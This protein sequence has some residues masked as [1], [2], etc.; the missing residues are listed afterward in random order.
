MAFVNLNNSCPQRQFLLAWRDGKICC[1]LCG[2]QNTY[3]FSRNGLRN[4]YR[5]SHK[6]AEF[7][8]SAFKD[9][10]KVLR[11]FVTNE[12]RENLITLS[13]Q[14]RKSVGSTLFHLK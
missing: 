11:E 2:F 7:S 4:H 12:T 10:A 5:A 3:A 6:T 13:E 9:G 14:R 8:D 1:S